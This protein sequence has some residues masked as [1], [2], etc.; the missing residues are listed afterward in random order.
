[1]AGDA[2]PAA[3]GDGE[4]AEAMALLM[5][6]VRRHRLL[7]PAEEIELARRVEEGDQAA[8]ERMVQANLRLVVSIAHRHRG[9]GL[10]MGDMVQEG[11]IGLI[12]AVDRFDW[13]R[14]LRFSTYATLWVRQAISRAVDTHGRSLRVPVRLAQR[15]RAMTRAERELHGRLGRRPTD[16]EV[17]REAGL[18]DGQVA[19]LRQAARRVSSLDRPVGEAGDQLTLGDMLAAP[20]DGADDR[21][22]LRMR[23]RALH[24]ALRRLPDRSRHVVMLRHG[25]A[26]RPPMTLAEIGRHLGLSAERV[27]Q[28]EAEAMRR[29]AGERALAVL[30]DAA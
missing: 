25:L 1:M 27:R 24:A 8:R 12:R 23:R 29:L 2:G 19:D 16:A 21:A 4:T 17:A 9:H 20:G 30:A 15:E 10:A 22:L 26:A 18:P 7:T 11:V 5:R 3:G 14:G 28:I 6:D 13:R